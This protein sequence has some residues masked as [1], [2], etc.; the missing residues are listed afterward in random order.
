MRP[1]SGVGAVRSS[2]LKRN[3]LW[4]TKS[5]RIRSCCTYWKRLPAVRLQNCDELPHS[6]NQSTLFS[7]LERKLSTTN[8]KATKGHKIFITLPSCF[9]RHIRCAR[10]CV[11]MCNASG[12]QRSTCQYP[13]TLSSNGSMFFFRRQ[14]K[15]FNWHF[16]LVGCAFWFD[17]MGSDWGRFC[18]SKIERQIESWVR[19]DCCGMDGCFHVAHHAV[20]RPRGRCR[21]NRVIEF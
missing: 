20:S 16:V 18:V 19:F 13:F 21:S 11:C 7:S 5:F 15:S 14:I 1:V 8:G 3:A 2:A 6:G 10:A 9:E 12:R 17:V 4:A